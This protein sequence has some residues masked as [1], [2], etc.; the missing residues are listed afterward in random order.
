MIVDDTS[1]GL[2]LTDARFERIPK[3][4]DPHGL[5]RV[6]LAQAT[7]YKIVVTDLAAQRDR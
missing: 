6:L 3:V 4:G 7:R 5:L 1:V 2:E